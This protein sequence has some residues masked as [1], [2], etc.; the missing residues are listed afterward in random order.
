MADLSAGPD[1][2]ASSE[3]SP[4]LAELHA[5]CRE[6]YESNAARR[7]Q[8]HR[9]DAHLMAAASEAAGARCPAAHPEDPTPCDGPSVVTVLDRK[10]HGADGCEHHAARLLASLDG[11]RV[12]ALL[13]APAGTA[14]RVFKAADSTRPFAWVTD[15]P[16]TR[17]DQLSCRENRENEAGK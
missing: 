15:G 12:Y 16:R 3:T 9:D 13:A 4:S 5:L 6:D 1:A 2:S 14:I 11:G 7:A 17:P 10:N 8:D